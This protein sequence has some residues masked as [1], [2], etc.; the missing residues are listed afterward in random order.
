MIAHLRHTLRRLARSPGYALT[1]ILTLGLALGGNV[2]AVSLVRRVLLQ[3][4][5]YAA[6]ER[7]GVL[8]T[9]HAPDLANFNAS[10]G[11]FLGWQERVHA[12]AAIGALAAESVTLGGDGAPR[13]LS[14]DRAT[15]GIFAVYR[16]APA[17]GRVFGPADD[18]PGAPPVA[19]ISQR[20]WQE[21]FASAADVIGR[22]LRLDGRLCTIVGVMPAEFLRERA[23]DVWLPMAFT[24]EE[25]SDGYRGARFLEVVGRLRTGV[26]WSQAQAEV[27]AA[28]AGLARD[29]PDFN[30]GWTASISPL[31]D[32]RARTVRAPLWLLSGA[33]AC[34]L[35]VACA[36]L[37]GISLTRSLSREHEFAV[38][39][40]LGASRGRLIRETLGE[41]FLLA[42][43]GGLAGWL[44]ASWLLEAFL[45]FAP[46]VATVA[47]P[48]TLD[49]GMLPIAAVLAALCG[50]AAGLPPALH[51]AGLGTDAA[52]RRADRH[53]TAGPRQR[54]VRA[55]LAVVQLGVALALLAGTLLLVRSLVRL[56]SSDPGFVA[57]DALALQIDLPPGRYD[58]PGQSDRFV[59]QLL[60]RVRS[61]PGVRAAGIA[62]A[63]PL[64]GNWMMDFLIEGQPATTAD[65]N[66]KTGY[67]AV[68]PGYFSAMGIRL[69]QGRA[70][71][72]RDGADAEPV[73]IV[74]ETFAR[75]HFPDGAAL[76]RRIY[77]MNGPWRLSRI[78]GIVADVKQTSLAADA[79]PQAYQPLAQWP[80]RTIT[81]VVRTGGEAAAALPAA[82]RAAVLAADPDQP[83]TSLAPLESL[84]SGAV[85][86]PRFVATLLAAFAFMT[87]VIAAIGLFA[88][89]MQQVVVRRR[90]FGIRLAL[91]ATPG[92]LQRTILRQGLGLVAAGTALGLAL[93]VLGHP[94]LASQL[95]RPEAFDLPG[96]A[97]V[98]LGAAVIGLVA[99]WLP[100]RRALRT[101]PIAALKAE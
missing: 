76:G 4:P 22:T 88:V 1:V 100:A 49:R 29:F 25:R 18:R 73:A 56:V 50:L 77:L 69:R 33:L 13:R 64:R 82:L 26:T 94:L 6:A 72:D 46:A 32:Y 31:A 17:L 81:L 67:F 5:P 37:A 40:A 87:G 53:A 51:V 84:I 68:S 91:G 43:A 7:I 75:R 93:A 57:R 14:A 54:R 28:A 63:L 15:A 34:V 45:R 89:T 24:D 97:F 65:G 70:F 101:D 74:N 80:V 59:Q 3:P 61:L 30:R 52:L 78:V 2:V 95:D 86:L 48:M 9:A 55:G 92:E 11:D 21:Q 60:E 39:A 19:V 83:V 47:G 38:R 96:F 58:A 36:N 23:T 85:A 10:P 16:T 99:T 66:R 8:R 42:G 41:S 79:P 12:F 71:D 35:A 98:L 62:Q 20:F 90:E 44:T 27:D